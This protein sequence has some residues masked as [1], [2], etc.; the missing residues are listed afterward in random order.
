MEDITTQV[1]IEIRDEMRMT[2]GEIRNTNQRLDTTIERVDAISERL[3]GTNA[4]LD[5]L[6]RR[7]VESEVRITTELIAV[8]GAIREMKD[9]FL[10]DRRLAAQVGD[11]ERR[12]QALENRNP[13]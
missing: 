8:A 12:I 7:Q 4:R 1:L 2:R 6:E 10:E 11:H 13:G 3:D 5:R 9:V